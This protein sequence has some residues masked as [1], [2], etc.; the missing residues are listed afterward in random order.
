MAVKLLYNK[1]RSRYHYLDDVGATTLCGK[2]SA[3]G[4]VNPEWNAPGGATVDV[5]KRTAETQFYDENKVNLDSA[6]FCSLCESRHGKELCDVC[7]KVMQ[8]SVKREDGKITQARLVCHE[9]GCT[10]P[11]EFSDGIL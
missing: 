6:G 7:G 4:T 1:Y 9:H 3:W 8:P 2:F 5:E 11:M 10:K